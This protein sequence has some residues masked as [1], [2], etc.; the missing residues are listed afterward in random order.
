MFCEDWD[1]EYDEE[2]EKFRAEAHRF[3]KDL[4]VV[5]NRKRS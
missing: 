1:D 3:M 5:S 2:W 4:E